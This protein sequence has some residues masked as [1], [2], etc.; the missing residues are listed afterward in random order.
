M[1][2]ASSATAPSQ[3][4]GRPLVSIVVTNYNYGR[5]LGASIDSAL[6]QRYP[7]VEVIVVDDGSTD[8]SR[9]IIESYG[10][11]IVPV[12]KANGGHRSAVHPRLGVKRGAD[13]VFLA[14]P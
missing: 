13:R 7:N 9:E 2:S 1:S 3:Q 12:I 8:G 14:P 10:G 11:R 4:A 5:Y 6:G